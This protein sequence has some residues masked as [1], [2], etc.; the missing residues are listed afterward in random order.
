[1]LTSLDSEIHLAENMLQRNPHL[2]KV[3]ALLVNLLFAC[4]S[5]EFSKANELQHVELFAGDC[6]VT[7]AE[8]EDGIGVTI[9]KKVLVVIHTGFDFISCD[10]AKF[11]D[12]KK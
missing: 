10:S 11:P 7:R 6:A 12:V 5:L 8:G 9:Q 3:V 4:Q 1:M 2:C